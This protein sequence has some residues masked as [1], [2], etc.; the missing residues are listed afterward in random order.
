MMRNA[1]RLVADLAQ[2]PFVRHAISVAALATSAYLFYF[3][4]VGDRALWSSHEA[5]AAQHAQLMLDTGRWGIPELYFAEPDYQKPPLYYWFVA[6]VAKLRG[7]VVDGW[8]V[9]L[10]ASL[11]AVFGVVVV[12]GV[13]A[14]Y[15]RA[16]VGIVASLILASNLRYGWLARVGRIDMPLALAVMGVLVATFVGYRRMLSSSA[17][18]TGWAWMLLAYVAASAAVMLKGPIGLVLPCCALFLLLAWEGEPVW[19]WQ[20]GFGSLLHRFGVWWGIPLIL[21]VAGPWYIWACFATHGEF[22]KSFFLHHHWNRT[23]GVEGLKPEP[24]WYYLPQLLVDM[25]P[26]S[27]LIPVAGCRQLWVRDGENRLLGRFAVCW[28]AGMLGVLSLVRFKRHDYLL[29]LLP[30]LALLLAVHWHDMFASDRT[31][32][33]VRWARLFSGAVLVLASVITGGFLMARHGLSNGFGRVGI[34]RLFNDTDRLLAGELAD[35]VARAAGSLLPVVIAVALLAVCGAVLIR[36][37][38]PTAA[39]ASVAALCGVLFLAY[40]RF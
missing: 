31:R 30:G 7:G 24:V 37:W 19:P 34:F 16:A 33:D 40:V 35:A 26:W 20:R 21:L 25:F 11:A 39:A 1:A 15:S 23:L 12:Y 29:P 27:L 18:R 32:R 22:A 2:T 6:C 5:R 13:A 8:S 3:Y 4:R 17:P 9:R 10:P 36:L 38:R 28:S 14:A